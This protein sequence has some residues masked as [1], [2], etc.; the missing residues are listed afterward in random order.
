MGED[1]RSRTKID[2]LRKPSK[3]GDPLGPGEASPRASPRVSSKTSPAGSPR[4]N[5]RTPK[6]SAP[7]PKDFGGASVSREP[8]PP[9]EPSGSA[10]TKRGKESWEVSRFKLDLPWKTGKADNQRTEQPPEAPAAEAPAPVTDLS[11]KASESISN[12]PAAS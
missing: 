9:D 3:A 10:S 8:S 4:D 7:S 11:L 6:A 12:E 2:G 1:L 5:K